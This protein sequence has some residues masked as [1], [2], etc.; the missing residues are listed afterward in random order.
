MNPL[1]MEEFRVFLIKLFTKM[2]TGDFTV[3]VKCA[4]DELFDADVIGYS[5]EYMT[6]N[7]RFHSNELVEPGFKRIPIPF[8]YGM[9]DDDN[10][11]LEK[12]KVPIKEKNIYYESI[13][14]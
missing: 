14:L 11:T 4:N 1:I 12:V 6:I 2:A 7:V 9:S 3:K 13:V 5:Q 10:Y 8:G